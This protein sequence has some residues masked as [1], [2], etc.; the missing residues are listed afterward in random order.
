MPLRGRKG[1]KMARKRVTTSKNPDG[2]PKPAKDYHRPKMIELANGEKV[3]ERYHNDHGSKAV[4]KPVQKDPEKVSTVAKPINDEFSKMKYPPPRRDPVFR[5]YWGKFIHNVIGR[6]SFKE[7]QL[8][9]LEVLCDLYVEYD[10]ITSIIRKEGRTYETVSRWGKTRRMHPAVAQLDRVRANIR[11][12]TKQLD[13]FPKRDTAD[14][15][16]G[17]DDEWE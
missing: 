4:Y 2:T 13:L 7:A 1:K 8:A 12:Y 14:G 3:M 17:E 6:E 9:A 11:A 5:R 10:D 16:D 15:G